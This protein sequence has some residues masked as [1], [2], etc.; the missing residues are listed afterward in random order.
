MAELA[1]RV[2]GVTKVFQRTVEGKNLTAVNEVSLSVPRESVF[3]LLGPNGAGKTTLIKMLLGLLRPT[4]GMVTVL[5]STPADMK[6]KARLAFVTELPYLYGSFTPRELLRFYGQLFG[7]RGAVIDARSASLL[8][9]VGLSEAG[10]RRLLKFSKGMLQRLNIAIG[11]INDPELIF[12][13]EP[14]LGLDPVASRDT[15]LLLNRLKSEG[16]TL[17]ITSHVLHHMGSLCDTVAFMANGRLV[18]MKRREEFLQKT[19]DRVR[20]TVEGLS[21]DVLTTLDEFVRGNGGKIISIGS[22]EIS[23]YDA[24]IEIFGGA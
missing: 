10:N 18:S 19:R 14:L 17:F 13:D 9:L 4:K 12:F 23:L 6:V 8:R 2:D 21:H 15:L 16:K 20:F 5:G 3:G 11:L 7:L 24:Y 1:I 22:G